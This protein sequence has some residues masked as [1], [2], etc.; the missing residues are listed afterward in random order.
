MSRSDAM[1]TAYC[2]SWLCCIPEKGIP[3]CEAIYPN[4]VCVSQK[5]LCPTQEVINT[6]GSWLSEVWYG[7]QSAFFPGYIY[8][9]VRDDSPLPGDLCFVSTAGAKCA[10]VSARQNHLPPNTWRV[11]PNLNFAFSSVTQHSGSVNHGG[12]SFLKKLIPS[13]CCCHISPWIQ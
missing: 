5:S 8:V 11:S 6:R 10:C 2:C 1:I 7:S 9:V 13:V 4:N 3:A 12:V